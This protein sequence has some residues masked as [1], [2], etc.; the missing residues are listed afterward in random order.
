[1]PH[2]RQ[3]VP[4]EAV[5]DHQDCHEMASHRAPRAPESLDEYYWFCLQHVREYNKSWNY[6]RNM[7]GP[8]IAR[9]QYNDLLGQRPSWPFGGSINV[10][11][12]NES[13]S[14][15]F[16]KDD[17]FQEFHAYYTQKE[18][19]NKYAQNDNA[20]SYRHYQ[21]DEVRHEL[22]PKLKNALAKMSLSVPLTL[23]SLKERYKILVKQLHPDLH[24]PAEDNEQLLKEINDAY[25]TLKQYLNNSNTSKGI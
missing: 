19:D 24:G 13:F 20:Q 25:H 17:P 1:M 5:C 9:D 10:E 2:N 8:M 4:L 21:P 3:Y 11:R 15:N 16:A 14:E 18:N 22:S 6:Y 12:F 7:D 23:Q